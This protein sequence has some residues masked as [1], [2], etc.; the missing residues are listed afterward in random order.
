MPRP[1]RNID[2]LLMR[3][4]RELLPQT[5]CRGLSIRRLTERAGVNLGMFHYHF[6]TKENFVRA[7]LQTT[8]EQMFTALTLEA[9]QDHAPDANLRAA[10]LLLGR[11]ARDNR[12]LLLRIVADA[13]AGEPLAIEFLRANMGRHIGFIL[14]LVIAAQKAGLLRRI[15]PV[16]AL[17]L[18]ASGVGMPILAGTA[19]ENR[20]LAPAGVLGRFR[21][22]VLTDTA[23]AERVDVILAGLR[24]VPAAAARGR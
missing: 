2:D 4:G 24:P 5:G 14:D 10:V 11:F 15:A 22:Q 23:I 18:L 8:Y 1:S 12:R 16:Q 17:V 9:G 13:V 3:A 7:L 6:K 21:Q 19:L 20:G